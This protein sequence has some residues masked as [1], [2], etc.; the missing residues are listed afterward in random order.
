M[1]TEVWT[2]TPPKGFLKL[3]YTP[4]ATAYPV[5]EEH[6]LEMPPAYD[7]SAPNHVGFPQVTPLLQGFDVNYGTEKNPTQHWLRQLRIDVRKHGWYTEH[8]PQGTIR[9]GPE[10]EIV[11]G[12]RDDSGGDPPDDPFVVWVHVSALVV[13]P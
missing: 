9:Q 4:G 3:T 11:V 7:P 2:A 10:V 5:T 8:G 1:A 13:Y 12:L 6:V